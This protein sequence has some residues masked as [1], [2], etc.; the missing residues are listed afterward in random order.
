MFNRTAM[1]RALPCVKVVFVEVRL[2]T[3]A[4]KAFISLEVD[5]SI[6]VAGL[7][8][9]L[10]RHVVALFACPYEVIVRYSQL[11]PSILKT[12]DC[13]IGPFFWSAAVFFRGTLDFQAMFICSGQEADIASQ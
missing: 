8:Q 1:D 10:N 11:S 3:D 2:A 6:V 13:L 7:Q 12:D 5:I 4:I 9:L